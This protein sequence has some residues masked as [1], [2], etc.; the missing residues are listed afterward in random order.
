[1][2]YLKTYGIKKLHSG[3]WAVVDNIS[4][5]KSHYS[6][7]ESLAYKKQDFAILKAE[8]FVKGCYKNFKRGDESITFEFKNMGII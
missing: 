2:T 5:D 8:R 4:E 1:M 7:R 6:V 3:K